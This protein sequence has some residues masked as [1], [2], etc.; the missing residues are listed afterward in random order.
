MNDAR[1]AEREHKRA[2]ELWE[3]PGTAAALPVKGDND[4]A[5]RERLTRALVAVGEAHF[6]MAELKRD[7]LNKIRV[8]EYK[9]LP[10]KEAVTRFIETNVADWVKK[11]TALV[12]ETE[13]A[14]AKIFDL[15]PTPPARWAV[16]AAARSA[17]S[18]GKFTAEFRATP[19]PPKW[20]GEGKIAGSALTAPELRHFY[21][22]SLDKAAE[23]LKAR[24]H[25]A[26]ERCRD[27][28]DRTQHRDDFSHN[29]V[30]W[31]EKVAGAPPATDQAFTRPP[32]PR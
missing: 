12:E 26:F 2:I 1:C 29:C 6:F 7:E 28:S 23:P 10:T 19:I 22:E 24:A 5:G 30:T 31:L 14:Y 20:K 25:A 13:K 17:A 8:P 15:K 9:G 16:A 4:A 18:W 27:T 11:K 3:A 32:A 21:Y